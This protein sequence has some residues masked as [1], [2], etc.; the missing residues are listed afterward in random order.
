MKSVSFAWVILGAVLITGPVSPLRGVTL[1][2]D[3]GSPTA[4]FH[5]IQSAIDQAKA[6]DLVGQAGNL[7]RK[8][9]PQVR[10]N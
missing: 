9:Q 10:G 1:V 4:P 3:A 2:V 7:S 6:G 5:T 8:S